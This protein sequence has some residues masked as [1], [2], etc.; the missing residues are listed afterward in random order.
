ML[1]PIKF[2][3]LITHSTTLQ[4]NPQILNLNTE[5]KTDTAV[6]QALVK[7]KEKKTTKSGLCIDFYV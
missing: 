4:Y 7:K 6:Q 1:K 3:V 2:T 5:K